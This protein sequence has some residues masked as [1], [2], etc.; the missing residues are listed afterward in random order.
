MKTLKEY[1][2]NENNFF[3]N[4]G[5]G[6]VALIKKWL[7][8][9]CKIYGEYTING[10]CEI[11]IKGSIEVELQKETKFPD[12]IQFNYVSG[13]F[14][15]TGKKLTTLNGCPREVN[16]YFD[17]IGACNLVSL[18]GSPQK[19]G[20]SFYCNN[21]TMLKTLKGCPK[22]IG[23]SFNC[24][25]CSSLTS[26]EGGPQKVDGSYRCDRCGKNFTTKDVKKY[27][28]VAGGIYT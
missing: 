6:Q 8:K 2:L 5:I 3:K 7:D 24:S 15:L 4:L 20:G 16:S 22:E 26:L 11:D 9:Y 23:N 1:I 14:M 28:S 21:C 25:Q 13:Y 18:E 12:Y 17:C 19:V 10:D 27:C